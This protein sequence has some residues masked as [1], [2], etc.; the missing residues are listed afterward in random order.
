ML[1]YGKHLYHDS[2]LGYHLYILQTETVLRVQL[3]SI[4]QSVCVCVRVCVFM[5]RASSQPT[6]GL[7]VSCGPTAEANIHM[8]PATG[9]KL[10]HK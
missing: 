6:V 2:L 5:I 10:M 1:L 3:S 9:P 8:A 7:H 4:C